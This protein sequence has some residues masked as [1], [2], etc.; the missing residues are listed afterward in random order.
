M[1]WKVH[2]RGRGNQKYRDSELRELAD[3]IDLNDLNYVLF[4][5][6]YMLEDAKKFSALMI[7][8]N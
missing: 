4:N 1:C 7:Q 8:R 6:V 2:G 5:N 3:A